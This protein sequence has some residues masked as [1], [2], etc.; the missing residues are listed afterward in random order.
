MLNPSSIPTRA[1][2]DW[3]LSGWFNT[4]RTYL[5]DMYSVVSVLVG[6][7]ASTSEGTFAPAN[8]QSVAANVTGLIASN[9]YRVTRVKYWVR[10]VGSSTVM[11]AGELTIIY[12]GTNFYLGDDQAADNSCGMAFD[13][14]AST[15][16]VTYTSSNLAGYTSSA[17]GFTRTTQGTI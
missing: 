6:A 16:Q 11:T 12:D 5:I 9:L 14:D 3:I 15:G 13:V 8:N 2:G 7:G 17:M 1:N 10:R 4:L